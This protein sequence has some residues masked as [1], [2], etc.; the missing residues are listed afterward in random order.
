MSDDAKGPMYFATRKYKEW[1]K[2]EVDNRG[3]TYKE[4][5]AE[6]TRRGGK[7]TA[8][9]LEQFLAKPPSNT[10]LMPAINKA[11][12]LPAPRHYDPTTPLTRLH[13]QLDAA[14]DKLPPNQQKALAL[15]L[16]G[17]DPAEA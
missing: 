14:W 5:A 12:G 9:A 4:F 7:C 10:A 1:V 2:A 16:T 17:D 6:V 13:Q 11:V 15:M 3:W 8:Q